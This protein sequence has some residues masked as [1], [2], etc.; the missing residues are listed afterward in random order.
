RPSHR[1]GHARQQGR[2]PARQPVADRDAA[3]GSAAIPG[4]RSGPAGASERRRQRRDS[5]LQPAGQPLHGA[6][7]RQHE[8]LHLVRH[9]RREPGRMAPAQRLPIQPLRQ[10]RSLAI[11]L[12]PAAD[13]PVPAAAAVGR[14]A[15]AGPD[16]SVILHLRLVPLRR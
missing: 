15:D 13:L 4:P 16:L 8:Q 2:V 14:E 9:R 5:R 3:A 11:Q 7:R 1:P 12:Q 6:A 10:P